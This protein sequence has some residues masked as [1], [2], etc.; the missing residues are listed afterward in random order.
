[1]AKM[2]R[3]KKKARR[4]LLTEVKFHHQNKKARHKLLTEVKFDQDQVIPTIIH[5]LFL[6]IRADIQHL[7]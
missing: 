5:M 1:M 7:S 2:R 3:V 4:E 6:V